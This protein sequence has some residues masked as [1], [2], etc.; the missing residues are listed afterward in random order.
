[1]ER[2][3]L[4]KS[5]SDL[6]SVMQT[7]VAHLKVDA[8]A[9]D[10]Q[11]E[12]DAMQGVINALTQT[13]T[14]MERERRE[15]G[16]TSMIML[17]HTLD[18]VE[19]HHAVITQDMQKTLNKHTVRILRINDG[20]TGE[21]HLILLPH[22]D[23][24]KIEPGTIDF[25]GV[26]RSILAAHAYYDSTHRVALTLFDAWNEWL[27]GSKSEQPVEDPDHPTDED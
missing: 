18:N 1:M 8:A 14:D 10:R 23:P 17:A 19:G 2:E 12:I 16:E 20:E 26:K 4:I 9:A 21:V 13:A 25:T 6:T 15:F 11:S 22:D 7:L 24:S 3:Q 5:I 27:T